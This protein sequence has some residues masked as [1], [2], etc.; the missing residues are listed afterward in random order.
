MNM[1]R[2]SLTLLAA[3]LLPALSL[4]EVPAEASSGGWVNSS[5][6]QARLATNFDDGAWWNQFAD[7]VLVTLVERAVAS[8][9]DVRIAVE[10]AAAARAGES[11]T[12]SKLWPAIDLQAGAS[13][14]R[15]NQPA[16]VKQGMPDTRAVQ[17]GVALA[18]EIDLAGGMRAARRAAHSDAL[19]AQAGIAG[20]RLL[21]A[22]EV[23]RQYYILRGAQERLRI[24][25]QLAAA[26]RETD[27]VVRSREREGLASRFDVARAIGEAETL[28]AQVPPLRT[29]VGVT[30]ARIAV[31]LG[32]SPSRFLVE[33]QPF[34]WPASQDIG[35]GQPSELLRRRPDLMAAE[36]RFAAETKRVDEARAQWW[37]KLFLSALIG[38]QD[39]K[40]NALDLSPARFTNVALAFG[41]PLFN[42]G[43]IRAGIDV[44]S[45]K[46]RE[47]LATW[48]RAVLVAV[49]EVEDSLLAREQEAL[50]AISLMAAS[51][52]RRA[53]LQHAQ[54]LRREGQIDLL[55]LLDVQR[56]L[57]AAELSLSESRTQQALNSVQLYKALGGGW[58]SFEPTT[59]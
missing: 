35:S 10:H 1:Y 43:R 7:P 28:D 21:A 39:L 59:R 18:W 40:L 38:Q 48:H 27:R 13:D 50:R 16:A 3:A 19:A 25:E 44:Q 11:A 15:T 57:L 20:A 41:M 46:A 54:S 5:F 30:Q 12:A 22:S 26:Q 36:A 24:V 37:P 17:A 56:A 29:L 32:E 34:A 49:E 55:P 53:S 14:V 9:L 31:L 42:A 8:N 58:A 23:A 45:A 6:R 4:G 33:D 51:E 2:I 47:H 52:A